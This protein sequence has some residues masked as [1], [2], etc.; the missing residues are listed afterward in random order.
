MTTNLKK[1]FLYGT[2][3]SALGFTISGNDPKQEGNAQ[4]ASN[5]RAPNT[6]ELVKPD[7]ASL[8][9]KRQEI[10]KARE[11]AAKANTANPNKPEPNPAIETKPD[12]PEQAA[13]PPIEHAI[14]P[15]APE[16]HA[17]ATAPP[18]A[19][20]VSETTPTA[21]ASRTEHTRGQVGERIVSGR[22]ASEP[23]KFNQ[24][25]AFVGSVKVDGQPYHVT[26]YKGDGSTKAIY[27]PDSEGTDCKNGC[28]RGEAM[29]HTISGDAAN[30]I[31]EILGQLKYSIIPQQTQRQKEATKL[32]RAK[33][34]EKEETSSDDD[35]KKKV[36]GRKLL[37][38]KIDEKCSSRI[39]EKAELECKTKRFVEVLKAE[40]RTAKRKK[41]KDKDDDKS[42]AISD[43]VA[44][45]YFVDELKD[46]L[47]DL[48][49]HNFTKELG[50]SLGLNIDAQSSYYDKQTALRDKSLANT[51]IR[52]LMRNLG[53]DYS[54]T[55]KEVASL[56]KEATKAQAEEVMTNLMSVRSAHD[57]NDRLG[58]IQSLMSFNENR[59][60]LS[61]LNNDLYKSLTDGAR[62]A[63]G[64]GFLERDYYGEIVRELNDSRTS[65]MKDYIT[66]ARMLD[67]TSDISGIAGPI[68]VTNA[69]RA[70][71]GNGV[72]SGSLGTNNSGAALIRTGNGGRIGVRGH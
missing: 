52:D 28:K 68:G 41:N 36:S 18:R 47:K 31:S 30:N 37:E 15:T 50:S 2:L 45:E 6:T 9:K 49:T 46:Y 60:Y 17:E 14:A 5:E 7:D 65:I 22:T 1:W 8:E 40:K 71:R 29:E 11:A 16:T 51:L 12:V 57:S 26:L 27:L 61:I 56:H 25:G 23:L 44:A 20:Q 69:S 66:D 39:S 42:P 70:G 54:E 59:N 19:Q 24:Y 62:Y 72:F 48:L 64:Q 38:K 58:Y 55:R 4:L 10:L 63:Q 32:A 67:L 53:K 3:L 43:D 21:N 33:E 34:K 35:D 13:Q